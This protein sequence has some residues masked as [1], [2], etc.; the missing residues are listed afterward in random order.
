MFCCCLNILEQL[1][2][3][4]AFRQHVAD[5]GTLGLCIQYLKEQVEMVKQK[6]AEPNSGGMFDTVQGGG[7]GSAIFRNFT[8]FRN[9]FF[10]IF[11]HLCFGCPLSVLHYTI[12]FRW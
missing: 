2:E 3:H 9:F 8:Q 5:A 12:A 10:A 6:L 7:L 4:N 11:P 1:A